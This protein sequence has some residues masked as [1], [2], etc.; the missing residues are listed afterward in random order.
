M[1]QVIR[2]P[3][4][5]TTSRSLVHIRR[6]SPSPVEHELNVLFYELTGTYY[7]TFEPD[8]PVD[9]APD[10]TLTLGQLTR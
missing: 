1:T 6:P 3:A 10:N 4:S 8:L 2:R 9:F 5:T 7:N